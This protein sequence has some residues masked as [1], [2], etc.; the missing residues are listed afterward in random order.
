MDLFKDY[1]S[2]ETLAAVINKTPYV[3]GQLGASGLFQTIGLT[4]TTALIEELAVE[5]VAESS[6]IPRG[7][8]ASSI[9]LGNRKM[10]PFSVSTYAWKAAVLA[11]EVL[12]VRAAGSGAAEVITTR[13]AENTAKLRRKA[14]F[15]HEYLRMAC[16]NTPTNTIGSAPASAAVAFGASDS[17]IR[18]AIHN[19]IVLPLETALA[20]MAYGG[21][22][23]Y[24]SDTFWLGLIESKT[25]RE[26]YLNTAAAAE[27]RNAPAESFNYGGITWHRYRAGGNCAVAAGKAKIVPRGVSGLFFQAFAPN[28][29]L[30]S[31]GTGAMGQPIYLDSLPID[32]DKGY[33]MTLQ[34]HPIMVCARPEAILTIG[35]S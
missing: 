9:S 12:N 11:D 29:T 17:A 31:V 35:L 30:T 10:H 32:G 20:G 15:Q 28:D 16:L 26:T 6:A 22:D 19:S 7:A 4:S 1:F 3:P 5:T 24:C 13:I 8:P 34:T 18:T 27:L 14:E 2:R 25:I 23:A 21:I 33:V